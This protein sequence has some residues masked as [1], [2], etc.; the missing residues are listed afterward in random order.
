M[1]DYQSRSKAYRWAYDKEYSQKNREKRIA[2]AKAWNAANRGGRSDRERK[3]N[4]QLRED[5]FNAYGRECKC[6]GEKV[7]QFLTIDHIARNGKAHRKELGGSGAVFLIA[8]KR[9]G[10]PKEGIQ[11][12]C[13]N[14]NFATRYGQSC[15]HRPSVD[16]AVKPPFS[17]EGTSVGGVK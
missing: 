12:L 7:P 11:I 9:L 8:L 15:P 3:R 10:W 4:I 5:M 1:P 13:M 6:C 14:C 17:L 2:R 16:V